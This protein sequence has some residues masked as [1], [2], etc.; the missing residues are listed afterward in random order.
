MANFSA[1]EAA[2]NEADKKSDADGADAPSSPKGTG[3]A[4]ASRVLGVSPQGYAPRASLGATQ[5][6]ALCSD[7]APFGCKVPSG[8]WRIAP[9]KKR[10]QLVVRSPISFLIIFSKHL[11]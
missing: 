3:E 2:R 9:F 8:R 7:T 10:S 1:V 11:P 6:F 4:S 5:R